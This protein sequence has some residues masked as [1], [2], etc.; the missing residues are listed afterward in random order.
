MHSLFIIVIIFAVII[1]IIISAARL[2]LKKQSKYLCE[3]INR[4]PFYK[5][6]NNNNND[7]LTV[8]AEHKNFSSD[9]ITNFE[10]SFADCY[11]TFS[12]EEAFC[13]YYRDYYNEAATLLS[14]LKTFRI[15][16]SED[17]VKLVEDFRNIESRVKSHNHQVAQKTLCTHKLFF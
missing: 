1:F 3:K 12:K 9:L 5:N 6:E 16:P 7:N 8:P 2:C 17:I 11:I 14:K 13:N 4:I 15:K 10:I